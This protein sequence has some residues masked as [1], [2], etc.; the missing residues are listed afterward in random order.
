M[1]FQEVIYLRYFLDM[2]ESEMAETLDIPA[3]TV[4]SRLHRA[5]SK[6]RGIIERDY[7]ELKEIVE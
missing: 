6:L 3:G 5:L 4:K 7:P 2:S 1:P